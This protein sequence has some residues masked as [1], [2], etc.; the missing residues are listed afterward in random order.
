MRK[1][2]SVFGKRSDLLITRM[3]T[4]MTYEETKTA[5]DFTY[6]LIEWADSDE[7]T[8]DLPAC[9]GIWDF[10]ED[11]LEMIKEACVVPEA[12]ASIANAMCCITQEEGVATIA[13]ALRYSC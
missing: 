10:D 8:E 7:E 6:E 2:V 4:D 11:Q 5:E 12:A 9:F 1:I 13:E 3:E